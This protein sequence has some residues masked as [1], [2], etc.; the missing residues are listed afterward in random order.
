MRI[1]SK[2][3]YNGIFRPAFTLLEVML[4]LSI[5]SIS[6]LAVVKAFSF[7][8][9]SYAMVSNRSEATML[10]EKKIFELTHG[11]DTSDGVFN[12]PFEKYKWKKDEVKRVNSAVSRVR[13]AVSWK[14][15]SKEKGI[16]I[17]TYEKKP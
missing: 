12:F 9:Q 3:T 5:V 4:A 15:N 7:I 14:E 6:L 13:Y 10:L 1:F 8:G 2:K 17:F 11:L 16:E